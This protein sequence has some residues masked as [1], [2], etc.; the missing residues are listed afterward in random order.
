MKGTINVH[1]LVKPQDQQQNADDNKL[2]VSISRFLVLNPL[3]SLFQEY[4]NVFKD[5]LI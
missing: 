1:R 3:S 2:Y 5:K 4:K